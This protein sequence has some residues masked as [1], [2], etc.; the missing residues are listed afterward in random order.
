MKFVAQKIGISLLFLSLLGV[1]MIPVVGYAAD[2]TNY[3]ECIRSGTNVEACQSQF[4]EA[5]P[6]IDPVQG[7]K[8]AASTAFWTAFDFQALLLRPILFTTM[9]IVAGLLGLAG[10]LLDQVM[11]RTVVNFSSEI[12]N[13]KA[14]NGVWKTIRDLGNMAYIFIL[15]Y[16]GIRMVLGTSSTDV[17]KVIVGIITAALLVNFSLFFTK[18]V[19]D[20]S[21][22]ATLGFYNSISA[23]V[24]NGNLQSGFSTA[25]MTPLGL[26][27][28]FDASGAS[29]ALNTS[30]DDSG[31]LLIFY[32]GTIIFILIACFVFL[33]ISVLFVLRFVVFIVLLIMSPLAF[34][35][36]A[37]PGLEDLQKK[38]WGTLSAQAIFGPLY[39]LY[40][41][42]ILRLMGP[43]G[44]ASQSSGSLGT[45][46][47]IKDS[48]SLSVIINFIILIALLLMS[49]IEAKKAATKGSMVTNDMLGKGQAYLGGAVFGGAAWAGRSTLGRYGSSV[50][51]NVDLQNRAAAGDKVARFKLL[52]GNKLAASSF[53]ARNTKTMEMATGDI[54]GLGKIGSFGKG[55]GQKGYKGYVEDK[56]KEQTKKDKERADQFKISETQVENNK[57]LRDE[58]E[59]AIKANP[60][61][62]SDKK[63][64]RQTVVMAELLQEKTRLGITTLESEIADLGTKKDLAEQAKK[65]T[66][67]KIKK[68]KD[69]I[70]VGKLAGLSIVTETA[71]LAEE[72]KKIPTLI[73]ELSDFALKVSQ[74]KKALTSIERTEIL[75]KLELESKEFTDNTWISPEYEKLIADAG[76]RS[77][78]NIK[79]GGKE[80][81]VTSTS[82]KNILAYAKRVEGKTGLFSGLPNVL[83]DREYS[84]RRARAA[85]KLAKAEEKPE[86]LLKKALKA[87]KEID[88]KTTTPDP[89]TPAAPTPPPTSTP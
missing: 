6:K 45:A 46:F 55:A 22:I 50:A 29:D 72:E 24:N 21:N 63:D 57:E 59:K 76:G 31:K 11:I 61:I 39:M 71:D 66:E 30:F 81:A 86:D 27:G 79:G 35:A 13:I 56:L 1:G 36:L 3:A 44:I 65:D 17:K 4:P 25:L 8:D 49:L 85:K 52:A 43:G 16:H 77:E 12:D 70:A 28:A 10:L 42:L 9:K 5:S 82:N 89:V 88:D 2:P 18:V 23:S 37:I 87:Q 7:T 48:D 19:L 58:Y 74:K 53:D 33:A 73:N 14:I 68:L 60:S 34:L 32:I 54:G 62:E 75:T 38:Y 78:R 41:W 26:S 20:A 40:T 51:N 67:A 47:T 83:I 84:K 64:A 80:K 15:L 69:D